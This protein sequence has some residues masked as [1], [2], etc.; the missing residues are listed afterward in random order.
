LTSEEKLRGEARALSIF[1][2]L[3]KASRINQFVDPRP[4]GSR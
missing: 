3:K 2:E 1:N 4:I